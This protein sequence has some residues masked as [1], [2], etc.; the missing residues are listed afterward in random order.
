MPKKVI[1][2]TAQAGDTAN[3]RRVL[4][5]VTATTAEPSAAGD[6]VLLQR[7]EFLHLFFAVAGTSP[8]FSLQVWWYSPISG[9]WHKGEA[10]NINDNDLATIEVQGLTR[11]YLQVTAISGSA[12]PTLNTWV[13]L[14]VP[15]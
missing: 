6:G 4:S 9:L 1:V 7:N 14:V 12:T 10:M 13:G 2:R 8:V 3:A 15:A 11:V 5:D